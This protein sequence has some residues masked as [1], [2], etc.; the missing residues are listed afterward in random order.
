ML[1]VVALLSLV[2]VGQ[3]DLEGPKGLEFFETK[4]RPV[5]ASK[6]YRCHS[7]EKRQRSG[8][9]LDT[10]EGL[11][12]GGENGAALVPGRPEESL[13]ILALTYED[14]NLRMPPK[15]KLPDSVVA[16]FVLWVKSG[17]PDPR[18]DKNAVTPYSG[19]PIDFAEARRFWSF[20][21]I[22]EPA[23]PLVKNDA[24]CQSPLDRLVLAHLE[25]AGLPPA[26][27]ASRR[28]LIRRVTY[29]L[30][31]LPPTPAEI[32][33]F[34]ATE[35]PDSYRQ[36]VERLL[37]SPHYGEKWGRH[38]LDVARYAD[39]NGVDENLAYVNAFRYRDYVIGAFNDDLPYDRFIHEQLAGDLL[40]APESEPDSERFKRLTATGFL[41]VGPKMLACDDGRKMELDIVDEQV[42]TVSRSF[43]GLTMGCARCHDHKFDP[44]PTAD[45]YSMAGIFKSTK[46]MENFRVVADWHEHVLASAEEEAQYKA[47]EAKIK[48]ATQAA[49]NREEIAF[50]EFLDVERNK[51]VEYFTAA[52][53]TLIERSAGRGGDDQKVGKRIAGDRELNDEILRPW[54]GFLRGVYDS[55]KSVFS[56]WY[57]AWRDADDVHRLE[58]AQEYKAGF[59][60]AFRAER[61][62]QS[63]AE[64]KTEDP[65][66]AE[67]RKAL[68]DEDGPFRKPPNAVRFVTESAKNE[69]DELREV[70][71]ELEN[72]RPKL[73][74][75]MG[76]REGTVENLP[77]HVRGNYLTP[78]EDRPR[79][80]PQVIAGEEQTP[81]GHDVSGRLELAQWLTKR[82][83]PLTARVMA[84]RI[85]QWHFGE[86]LVRTPDNFG[87]LGEAPDNKP[88]LDWL[89]LQFV[90]GG[91][92]MKALHRV[93]L[94]SATY[95]MS[96]EYNATAVEK[97]PENRLWWRF[98]RRR[99][100]AEEIRDSLIALGGHLDRELYGQL[101]PNESRAYV[102]GLGGGEK[103]RSYYDLPRRS[104][105]LPILR[106]SLY[107]V[108]Q[109]F[110]FADPSVLNGK[111][112]STTVAPQALFMM[113]AETV[114]RE[115]GH[116]AKL[117]A[118]GVDVGDEQRVS[119]LY[120]QCFG[121]L[122]T[123]DEI[124]GALS[125]LKRYE[126][127]LD[128][129]E[130]TSEEK[131]VR[132]WQGLC[133]VLVAA[134]EFVYID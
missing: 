42:D 29:G 95:Q 41:S 49:L 87:R 59:D 10:Y 40:A 97:D 37:A 114:L 133:R 57:T 2:T 109:T 23:L 124:A 68:F 14:D 61:E 1:N 55:P 115:T 48:A 69:L 39:S 112:V 43:M 22:R 13:L 101:L 11:L 74:R 81:I 93:I 71:K 85:W 65:V 50:R 8:L 56:G 27:P 108:F 111:R 33:E 64:E 117:I 35:D 19:G 21:P 86:G 116:L 16:D 90:E 58:L 83:H 31:G 96:T 134:N 24:W 120:E 4:I 30:T 32:Q 78:G 98:P 84:N 79:Q 88:L 17:A 123:D 53:D 6:C 15:G 122:P 129:E 113:N 66:Q 7:E 105:Y 52:A 5:L 25:G 94:N 73:D 102:A 119:Q 12:K 130:L 26:P 51:A 54:I 100:S 126:E 132:T 72:Q 77:V 125:F 28:A 75:A 99:L 127:T 92:S 46:T 110:D 121:R 76:V 107:Q 63:G 47:H 20:Q 106:S 128:S 18:A 103:G 3:V 67:L 44:L 38:W 118:V 70:Q 131:L 80:F 60:T 9:A 82:D 36:L 62:Q 104:V 45:Y 91:W 34:V 89:A